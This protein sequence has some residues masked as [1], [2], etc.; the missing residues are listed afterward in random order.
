MD[1]HNAFLH[2]DLQEDV[3]MCMPLG[4]YAHKPGMVCHLKRSLYGLRKAPQCWFAKLASALKEHG[5]KQPYSDY[6]LFTLLQG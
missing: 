6:S 5:F 1:V 3:Y 4:L 2:G